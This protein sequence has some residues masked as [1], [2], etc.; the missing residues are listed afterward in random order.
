MS[1]QTIYRA[2]N[3]NIVRCEIKVNNRYTSKLVVT[4]FR[5]EIDGSGDLKPVLTVDHEFRDSS[6][7]TFLALE[8]VEYDSY[9]HLGIVIKQTYTKTNEYKCHIVLYNDLKETLSCKHIF[10][11][12][13]DISPSNVII[14]HDLG[15][16]VV[17]EVTLLIVNVAKE[18]VLTLRNAFQEPVLKLWS[19]R[20]DEAFEDQVTVLAQVEQSSDD[21]LF[22]S[23]QGEMNVYTL[24]HLTREDQAACIKS[25]PSNFI[26]TVYTTM[27]T[28]LISTEGKAVIFTTNF[29]QLLLFENGSIAKCRQLNLKEAEVTSISHL[30]NVDNREILVLKSTSNEA[31]F[32]DYATFEVTHKLSRPIF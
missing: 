6:K 8:T 23:V 9:D 13:N 4:S 32:I 17:S 7:Y 24:K 19:I 14:T 5:C 12:L 31:I 16:F 3:G 28:A 20:R 26:P 27:V 22:R 29:K 2:Y 18:S 10:N 21:S 15:I 25:Q 30:E 1:L 11:W